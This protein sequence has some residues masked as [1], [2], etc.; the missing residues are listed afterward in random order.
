MRRRTIGEELIAAQGGDPVSRLPRVAFQGERGAF[1]EEAALRLLRGRLELLACPSFE[2]L[3]ASV[4]E[5]AADAALLPLENSTV[6]GLQRPLDLLLESSLHIVAE[7]ILPVRHHLIGGPQTVFAA[8]ETVESHPVALAQCTRFFA[9]HP[10]LQQQMSADTAASVRRVCQPGHPRLAALGSA[11]AAHFYGG[12]ILQ[13]DVQDSE[14]NSTRFVLVARQPAPAGNKTVLA[15]RLAHRPGSLHRVL[16][17]LASRGFDVLRIENRPVTGTPWQYHFTLDVA[18]STADAR[19][20]AALREIAQ[21]TE[22]CRVLGC[23]PAA[24]LPRRRTRRSRA[25]ALPTGAG[26]S[27]D[28]RSTR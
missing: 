3:V 14:Q 26:A 17:P 8:I 21:H 28:T 18:G 10:Q 1:S 15:V 11:R 19:F 25:R 20:S 23:F 9:L 16:Q 24:S 2:M 4:A 7:T 5:S 13:R 27:A 22:S 6:G 12:R